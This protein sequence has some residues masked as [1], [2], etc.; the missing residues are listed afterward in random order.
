MNCVML[1]KYLGFLHHF[2]AKMKMKNELCHVREI[3]RFFT[4]F[5]GQNEKMLSIFNDLTYCN[6]FIYLFF[7]FNFLCYDDSCYTVQAQYK[8]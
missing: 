6:L 8:R 2:L 7:N 3:S 5:F 4:P 1:G